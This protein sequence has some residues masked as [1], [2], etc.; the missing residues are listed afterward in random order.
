MSHDFRI[1]IKD[2]VINYTCQ[3]RRF[4]TDINKGFPH[5]NYSQTLGSVFP[6]QLMESNGY[7]LWLEY[8]FDENDENLYW[9]M[10]YDSD[11]KPTIP[12]SAIFNNDDLGNMIT[13]LTKFIP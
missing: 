9:L 2:E 7:T 10:W 5:G 3:N 11:G 13:Q 1:I 12:L 6:E 4:G 8:V